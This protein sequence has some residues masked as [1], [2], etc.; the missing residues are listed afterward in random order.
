[1]ENKSTAVKA[2]TW[3][4]DNLVTLIFLLF[5]IIGLSVS[6]VSFSWFLGELTGRLY[7]N[8]FL[9]LSLII[10]VIA[11]LGLNFGIVVGDGRA[12][13]GGVYPLL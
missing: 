11:G 6:E 9:V 5:T 4:G 1:M 2:L 8:S 10:P 3:I 12:D 7:R 13:R